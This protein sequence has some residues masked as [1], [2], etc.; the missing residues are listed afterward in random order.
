MKRKISKKKIE[1]ESKINEEDLQWFD[2]RRDPFSLYGLYKPK[3]EKVFRR[4][5]EEIASATSPQVYL[6]HTNTAGARVRFVTNSSYIA[7]SMTKPKNGTKMPHMPL[8]AITG[9]D[10]YKEVDEIST[11]E[12][13]FMPPLDIEDRYESIAYLEKD[14]NPKSYTIN[15]PLYDNVNALYIGLQ[16]DAL[17][18]KHRDYK[19]EKPLVFYG[20]SITQGGCA[21]RPGNTYPAFISR[22]LDCN[23]INLGFSG[24]A[25]AEKALVDYMSKLDMSLFVSDYDH[26]APSLEHL[27]NT[28]F[29]MYEKIRQAQENL[30]YIMISRPNLKKTEESDIKRR[31]IIYTSY[32]KA[33]ER[34]DKN[35]YFI[36]G[37]K[38]FEGIDRDACTIDGA[39]PNDI[40]F[41]RMAQVISKKIK[42]VLDL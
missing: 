27:K 16:K 17:L 23:Y 11:Y 14:N 37:E 1:I 41:I 42:V 19:I 9:F 26:N 25:K 40:G 13:S 6:L 24:G 18:E 34:G 39:H 30:P 28:H 3:E 32:Q 7:I 31:E 36:D 21:S 4:M 8:L 22:W 29:A 38:L 33:L 35:V 15:F 12:K 10:L 2:V 20:S 5:P